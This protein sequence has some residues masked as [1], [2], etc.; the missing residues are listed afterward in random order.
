MKI[1]SL[2]QNLVELSIVSNRIKQDSFKMIC[3]DLKD[4]IIYSDFEL[5]FI[6]TSNLGLFYWILFEFS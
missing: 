5:F 3:C 2:G 4:I 6:F 1:V